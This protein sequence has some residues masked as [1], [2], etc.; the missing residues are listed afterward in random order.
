MYYT[1]FWSFSIFSH[2]GML[3]QEKSGYF[4]S[5]VVI[6][7]AFETEDPGSIPVSLQGFLRKMKKRVLTG[8]QYQFVK[9]IFNTM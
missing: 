2:F 7:S 5:K 8:R 9:I 4:G 3:Y 1:Y 6:A